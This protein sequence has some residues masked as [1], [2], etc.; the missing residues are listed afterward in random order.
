MLCIT[1]SV[2]LYILQKV[3]FFRDL[4][5][6][7]RY[8]KKVTYACTN[9]SPTCAFRKIIH[10]LFSIA[11]TLLQIAVEFPRVFTIACTLAGT[12][13]ML[14]TSRY[15]VSISMVPCRETHFALRNYNYIP[16][17]DCMLVI[18]NYC[19]E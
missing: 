14:F 9:Y 19:A 12:L 10:I 15:L 8:E 17:Y 4:F 6:L 13:H 18:N 7:S 5:N 11:S 16:Y 3:S 2:A 1:Y